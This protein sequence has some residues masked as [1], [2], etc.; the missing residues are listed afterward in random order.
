M[1]RVFIG[2]KKSSAFLF[3]FILFTLVLAFNP[4][5]P[6]YS[7]SSQILFTDIFYHINCTYQNARDVFSSPQKNLNPEFI[8]NLGSLLQI[9]L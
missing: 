9:L 5:S 6:N 3:C 7:S 1:H 4:I 2:N 8:D